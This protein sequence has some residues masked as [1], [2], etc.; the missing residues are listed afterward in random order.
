MPTPAKNYDCQINMNTENTR[1]KNKIS[2]KLAEKKE[3]WKQTKLRPG[4]SY[5]Q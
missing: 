4:K 1:K 2:A 3:V 5:K